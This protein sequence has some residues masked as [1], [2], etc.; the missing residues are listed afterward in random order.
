[1]N[2]TVAARRIEFAFGE[3]AARRVVLRDVSLEIQ[4]GE[5]VLLTGP[6]GS[7]KTTLLSL[8]GALR[9]MQG[10]SL[11]VLDRELAGA[12]EEACR[13]VRREVGYIFQLHNLLPFITARENVALAFGEDS[14]IPRAE[15][16]T[17]ADA[18]LAAVGLPARTHDYGSSLSGGQKQ[19]VAIA[20]ALVHQPRLILADEPTASLDKQS[21]QD[22]VRL[23]RQLARDRGCPI[24]LVTHD[25]RIFDVADRIV[26][27]EDGAIVEPVAA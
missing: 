16:L 24:L 9:A 21:G 20:R 2:P 6:S 26:H 22:V 3:G 1:M 19:R 14:P 23:L 5:I 10:G 4:P 15:R 12:D 11:R 25:S 18:L 7:G 13:A 8:I 27:F 17:R